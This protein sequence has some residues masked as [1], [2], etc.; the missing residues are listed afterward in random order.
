[1]SRKSK[2]ISLS[3][4]E[5]QEMVAEANLLGMKISC[6]IRY[7]YLKERAFNRIKIREI[8]TKE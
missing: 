6:Y 7:L 3:D 1:M 8:K 2:S 5:Y 4:E